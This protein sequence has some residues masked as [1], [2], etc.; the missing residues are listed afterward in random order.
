MRQGQA[1]GER[2]T[3]L[4]EAALATPLFLLLVLGTIEGGLAFSERLTVAN[5]SLVGARAASGQGNDVLADYYTLAAVRSGSGGL[6]TA[7]IRKVVVYRAMG[8]RDRVPATCLSGSV[9]NSCNRYVAADL[10][11]TSSEF[12]CAGPPGPV[13]KIDGYWCPGTRKTALTGTQGPPDYVGV[14]VEAFHQDLTGIFG[15]S[16]TLRSDTVFRLEPRTVT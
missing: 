12:G 14:Y 4:L 2:G 9:A 16:L 6:S 13:A 1:R 7:Q 15:R 3:V 11:A 8:P 5:M 10:G